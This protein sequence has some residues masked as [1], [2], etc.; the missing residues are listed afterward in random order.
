MADLTDY[1][2]IGG[3]VLAVGIF[4][5]GLI[6]LLTWLL[7]DRDAFVDRAN[8]VRFD[9]RRSL[10]HFTQARISPKPIES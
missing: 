2:Y 5:V 1:L 3:G 7:P 10:N 4:V 9:S 6:L 8:G